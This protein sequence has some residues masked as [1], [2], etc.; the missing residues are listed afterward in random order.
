[1]KDCIS[2]CFEVFLQEWCDLKF[3]VTPKTQPKPSD[4][5]TQ[6]VAQ[7]RFKTSRID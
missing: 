5:K 1:M 4:K 6:Q 7:R 2:Q 3:G